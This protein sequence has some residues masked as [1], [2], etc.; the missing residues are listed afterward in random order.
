MT[1]FKDL[2]ETLDAK[3]SI[4]FY[5]TLEGL[6]GRNNR[7]KNE[8]ARNMLFTYGGKT[9][10][11]M[12]VEFKWAYKQI[13]KRYATANNYIEF[14]VDLYGHRNGWSKRHVIF[15]IDYIYY[16]NLEHHFK[17]INKGAFAPSAHVDGDVVEAH[18]EFKIVEI[19]NSVL[20]KG[21]AYE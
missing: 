4:S 8:K 20:E 10:D 2:F 11:L 13:F 3:I 21:V 6:E 5:Q 1:Y 14:I 19:I 17:A 9:A 12:A 16:K 7:N 15:V 18:E